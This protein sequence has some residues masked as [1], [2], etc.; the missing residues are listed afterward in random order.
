MNPV[1]HNQ[2]LT[3]AIL[4]GCSGS[5]KSTQAAKMAESFLNAN[6]KGRVVHCSADN[7]PGLYTRP[8]GPATLK[9]SINFALLGAAHA[10]CFRAFIDACSHSWAA[11]PERLTLVIVD[12]T[13]TS[14]EEI[15]P[16]I[17]GARAFGCEPT[18]HLVEAFAA[19]H[20]HTGAVYE[21]GAHQLAARNVHGAPSGAIQGQLDRIAA[22]VDAWPPFWPKVE[23]HANRQ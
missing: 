6:P 23:R 10:A 2:L 14:A 1:H 9:P 20:R 15:A 13:N 16:Y 7:Y 12:N 3:V 19:P 17:Q 21:M 4:M 11:M 8:E 18:V 22:V 5:G